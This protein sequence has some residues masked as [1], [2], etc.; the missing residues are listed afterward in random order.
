MA[1]PGRGLP[2]E[3]GGVLEGAMPQ[4]T[5]QDLVAQHL[6]DGGGELTRVVDQE[7]GEDLEAKQRAES[8]DGHEAA[9]A[10]E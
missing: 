1:L 3:P 5:P 4:A 8:A 10:G 9:V 6:S 2:G 7:T